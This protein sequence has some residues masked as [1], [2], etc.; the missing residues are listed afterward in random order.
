MDEAF[1]DENNINSILPT[2]KEALIEFKPGIYKYNEKIQ[3]IND[4]VN[5]FKKKE[6]LTL[7]NVCKKYNK[8]SG[9]KISK[10]YAFLVLKKY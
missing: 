2:Y 8:I 1:E 9:A 10:S 7:K 5:D 6:N 3:L 4:I